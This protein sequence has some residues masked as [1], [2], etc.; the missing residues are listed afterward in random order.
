M[1]VTVESAVQYVNQA[2]IPQTK[3]GAAPVQL[4][5]NSA[6]DQAA[7]IGSDV[8]S[9]VKGVTAERREAIINSSML[10][11]LVATKKVP[12]KSNISGWYDAYFDVLGNVGWVIQENN[13]AVYQE[14]SQNFEAHKAILAVAT[15]LLGAAPTALA[16]VTTT[17]NALRSMDDSR[18]WI[19]LFNRETQRGKAA[20]FQIG[21]ASE[22]Q[23]GHFTVSTMAFS[24]VAKETIT[25][26]LFF[27]ARAQEATLRHFSG[28][29]TINTTVLDGTRKALEKKLVGQANNFIEQLPDL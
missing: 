5:L 11:Q 27:K 1:A 7:V 8:L 3:A 29:V 10:A 28:K 14:K 6:K 23:D 26:V 19:S 21:L 17:I 15:T 20:R 18:P 2:D 25:Q 4:A 16:L 13:F 9:F 22:E 24:L 12:D